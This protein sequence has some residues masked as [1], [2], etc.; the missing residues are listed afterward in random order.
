MILADFL[1]KSSTTICDRGIDAS[2]LSQQEVEQL[3][4]NNHG[5]V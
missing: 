5:E 1:K 3:Y 4:N 2:R